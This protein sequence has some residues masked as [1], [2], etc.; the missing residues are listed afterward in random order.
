MLL[1]VFVEVAFGLAF[2]CTGTQE[3]L[4]CH[5]PVF[6]LKHQYTKLWSCLCQ[7]TSE[8]Q[9]SEMIWLPHL[10]MK[11]RFGRLHESPGVWVADHTLEHS[12]DLSVMPARETRAV[13]VSPSTKLLG[14]EHWNKWQK[15]VAQG[16]LSEC[17]P[18]LSC[19]IDH[20]GFS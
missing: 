3:S 16:G 20:T 12:S 18:L 6:V 7:S 5:T 2:Y 10:Q 13:V 19:G 15:S 8:L 17:W 11:L 14:I 4:Q 1:T 9:A